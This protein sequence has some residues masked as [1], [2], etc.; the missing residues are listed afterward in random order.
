MILGNEEERVL[1]KVW[2]W[3]TRVLH[4][5]NVSLILTL[6]GLAMSHDILK[7]MKV[8]KHFRH[9]LMTYHV[10]VGYALIVTV[11]LR[12]LWGFAGNEYARWRDIWPF[13]A[14][15]IE[16]II[17]KL[18]WHAKGFRGETKKFRYLGHDPLGSLFYLVLFLIIVSQM[19]TGL[20]LAG[21][22]KHMAPWQGFFSGLGHATGELIEDAAEE[23]HEFW[24]YFIIFFIISHV[25]AVVIHELHEKTGLLSSMV[26][27]IKFIPEASYREFKKRMRR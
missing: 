21:L 22:D 3:E 2:D 18:K 1:V 19:L 15:K 24:F 27:G 8:A 16:Y 5:I 14:E 13:T 26:N 6:M 11:I 10:Y 9:E 25:G 12:V 4:W 7:E 20:T 23:I 17:H